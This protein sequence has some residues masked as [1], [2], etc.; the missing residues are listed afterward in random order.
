MG[1]HDPRH[2][3]SQC[4]SDV[5]ARAEAQCAARKTRL[6]PQRREVLERIAETHAAV[7]AYDIIERMAAG[8]ER[9]APITVYRALDFLLANGLVHKIESRSA[10]VAC[11][12]E[13]GGAQA[14]ILICEACDSVAELDTP[15]VFGALIDAARGHG[16]LA[17]RAVVEISGRCGAC[18]GH[19]VSSFEDSQIS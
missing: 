6:T 10:Y 11:A 8:G 1:F 17:K 14:A 2:D 15:D 7:G 12:H 5:I 9:P 16:F 18:G 3:H 4:A 13:H 19:G